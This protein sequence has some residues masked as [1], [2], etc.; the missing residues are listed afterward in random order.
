M[1]NGGKTKTYGKIPIFAFTTIF[2]LIS[3]SGMALALTG[4][5]IM[6]NVHDRDTGKS[7]ASKTKMVIINDKG[8]ER[9]REVQAVRKDYGDL[10]KSLIRFLAP[11]D[12]KGTGFLIWENKD[13]DDDQFLY[14]PATGKVRRITSS[15]KSERFMGTEF[16][17][18]DMENRKV[19]K[20]V[21]KLL[22]EETIDGNKCYK[23]ES[24]PKDGEES[25]YSKFISWVRADIWVPVKIEFYDEE[26]ALLKVLKVKKIEKIQNIW[27]TKDSEMHNVQTDYK[28]ILNIEDIQY[29]LDIKD[30]YFTERYLKQG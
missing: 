27:T 23:V 6:Q 22:G 26:G 11:A 19:E 29:N 3:L 9:V 14:M 10:S 21:H 16:T 30:D 25:Q 2:F 18:E 12:V 13:V 28:T 20:D 8:Q 24:V 4:K 17:Y 1:K 15:S 7:S 5:E